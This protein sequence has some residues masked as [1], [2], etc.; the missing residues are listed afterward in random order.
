MGQTLF[1]FYSHSCVHFDTPIYRK[2]AQTRLHGLDIQYISSK[3]ACMA[4]IYSISAPNRLA[5]TRYTVYQLQA[6]LQG[7]IYCISA[8]SRL[9]WTRYTVYQLQTCL[10]GLDIQYI[11]SKQACMARYT[12]YQLRAGLHG[13]IYSIPTIQRQTDITPINTIRN[14]NHLPPLADALRIADTAGLGRRA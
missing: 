14:E 9:A 8:P 4:S 12:V 6:G 5:W 11:S 7:P 3:Q 13:P 10:H 1:A 2:S